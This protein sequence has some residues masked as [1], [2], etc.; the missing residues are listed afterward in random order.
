MSESS[1][2]Q[3]PQQP[4][5]ETPLLESNVKPEVKELEDHRQEIL[6]FILDKYSGTEY[7]ESLQKSLKDQGYWDKFKITV[8]DLD[9]KV[10][11]RVKGNQLTDE[12]ELVAWSISHHLRLQIKPDPTTG[13]LETD[14]AKT[15]LFTIA[16]NTA[17]QRTI[18]SYMEK[19][20][21]GT[22][23][24][25]LLGKADLTDEKIRDLANDKGIVNLK[26]KLA[27]KDDHYFGQKV[28]QG[29]H[30]IPLNP[31]ESAMLYARDAELEGKYKDNPNA[32]FAIATDPTVESSSAA[33]ENVSS[34]T[35][36]YSLYD[37]DGKLISEE[38]K[39][40]ERARWQTI[41]WLAKLAEGSDVSG[42]LETET[43][44]DAIIATI[45]NS[46]DAFS[47]IPDQA[48]KAKLIEIAESIKLIKELMPEGTTS[49][50]DVA[51]P[52][53]RERIRSIANEHNG[54]LIADGFDFLDQ[55]GVEELL[56]LCTEIE[57]E[58]RKHYDKIKSPLK[59]KVQNP[60]E[61]VGMYAVDFKKTLEDQ[62]TVALRTYEQQI[63]RYNAGLSKL[64]P[65]EIEGVFKNYQML[66]TKSGKVRNDLK[67]DPVSA[68]ITGANILS[69]KKH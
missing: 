38:E 63:R 4:K 19:M 36:D 7:L 65:N 67:I 54:K 64:T 14:P 40:A 46:K 47:S 23:D 29:V 41:I 61:L 60:A 50:S 37:K 2:P 55:I 10:P 26:S 22:Y 24:D 25:I 62:D 45:L 43:E 30:F 18:N 13:K 44:V 33:N 3:I 53:T 20:T 66:L 51:D 39:S 68:Y 48:L 32:F 58:V 56:A 1:A 31:F 42:A 8:V 6:V 52:Q 27:L 9:K 59:D 5:I 16:C 35:P 21:K 34:F 57:P 49:L 11:K 28:N 17:T 69:N 15:P 12:P